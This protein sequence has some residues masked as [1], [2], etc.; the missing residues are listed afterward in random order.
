MQM[1]SLPAPNESG[2][3]KTHRKR[4]LACIAFG[5]FMYLFNFVAMVLVQESVQEPAPLVIRKPLAFALHYVVH[6]VQDALFEPISPFLLGRDITLFIPLF[7]ITIWTTI[8]LATTYL[9]SAAPRLLRRN[10][11]DSSH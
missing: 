2:V 8:A 10:S 1:N 9:V 11:A 6:P 4:L 5:A 3:R 7:V